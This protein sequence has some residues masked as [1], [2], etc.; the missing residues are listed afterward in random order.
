V[1][2]E[3]EGF[4]VGGGAGERVWGLRVVGEGGGEGVEEGGD[5]VAGGGEVVVVG[6]VLFLVGVGLVVMVPVMMMMMMMELLW[7]GRSGLVALFFWMVLVRYYDGCGILLF[8]SFR[9]DR[10]S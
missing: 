9:W 8:G 7:L 1:E 3:E 10:V 2:G 5:E 6:H 4:C